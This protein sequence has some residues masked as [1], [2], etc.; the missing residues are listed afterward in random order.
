MERGAEKKEWGTYPLVKKKVI[1]YLYCWNVYKHNV[2]ENN[3]FNNKLVSINEEITYEN[4]S[5]I[6]EL[7]T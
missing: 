1:I 6:I 3:I 5:K 2:G 7:Q 4:K